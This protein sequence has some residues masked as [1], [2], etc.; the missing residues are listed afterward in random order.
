M[1]GANFPDADNY[2]IPAGCEESEGSAASR[3]ASG[4]QRQ[5]SDPPRDGPADLRRSESLQGA[6]A[7]PLLPRFFSVKLRQGPALTSRL[8]GVPGP[9]PRPA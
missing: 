1:D 8:A 6:E 5:L 3:G 4:R 9:G 2:L 7:D